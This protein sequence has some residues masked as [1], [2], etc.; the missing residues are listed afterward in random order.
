MLYFVQSVSKP[1]S[2][3]QAA[4]AVGSWTTLTYRLWASGAPGRSLCTSI[5]ASGAFKPWRT[6][7]LSFTVVYI[8]SESALMCL[9][10]AGPVLSGLPGRLCSV[11]HSGGL[12]ISRSTPDVSDQPAAAVPRPGLPL[13]ESALPT[14]GPQ[15][16]GCLWQVTNYYW[17][18]QSLAS[19]PK[20]SLA[21]E[22]IHIIVLLHV[23]TSNNAFQ[24][25]QL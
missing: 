2:E 25:G 12:C 17:D 5:K 14:A 7:G 20:C 13:P 1:R 22:T 15:H 3:P 16:R 23:L 24:T 8:G 19:K 4:A 6:Q 21:E 11:A 10:D 18:Y 9:Q